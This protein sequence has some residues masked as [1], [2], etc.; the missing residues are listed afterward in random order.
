MFEDVDFNSTEAGHGVKFVI[1]GVNW[2]MCRPSVDDYNDSISRL[3]Q[4]MREK[5]VCVCV[6]ACVRACV[7]VTHM[8]AYTW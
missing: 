5:G 2:I 3:M 6:C 1:S 7:C 8:R 4:G